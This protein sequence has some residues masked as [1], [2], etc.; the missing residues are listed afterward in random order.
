VADVTR[1]IIARHGNTFQPGETPRRIGA[2]TDLAL[3]STGLDQARALRRHFATNGVSFDRVLSSGLQRTRMTAEAIVGDKVPIESASFLTEI[4]HGPDE[5][6]TDA[7]ISA[8]IGADAIALW[9][10]QMISPQG[11]EVGAEWRVPAWRDF[12][13]E[14]SEQLPDGTILLVTSNGA[15]RFAL[16]ALGVK[17]QESEHGLKFRTGSYGRID[18]GQGR[19]RLVGWDMRPG[20]TPGDVGLF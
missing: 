7:T 2:R 15:A 3:T 13:E 10:K 18:I 6:Q 5:N 12:A 16:A 19:I 9:D 4:D 14:A 20:E 8:R 1:L 11:W 17:P